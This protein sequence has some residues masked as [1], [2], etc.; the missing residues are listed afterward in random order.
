[1]YR[2]G[3]IASGFFSKDEPL[4]S[5]YQYHRFW[6]SDTPYDGYGNKTDISKNTKGGF[7]EKDDPQSWRIRADKAGFEAYEKE[8]KRA[9]AIR[10]Y[11]KKQVLEDYEN[12]PSWLRQKWEGFKDGVSDLFIPKF[13]RKDEVYHG[14][15]EYAKFKE[16]LKKTDWG[17]PVARKTSMA[18]RKRDAE[19][20][21]HKNYEFAMLR[22]RAVREQAF[23]QELANKKYGRSGKPWYKQYLE[24]LKNFY[25]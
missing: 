3:K 11:T 12:A 1:M 10:D 25:S 9:E 7:T 23:N 20:L 2:F 24:D 6:G 16:D 18:D 17:R 5:K 14:S 19:Y 8:R 4:Y 21:A 15:P 13:L 22:A